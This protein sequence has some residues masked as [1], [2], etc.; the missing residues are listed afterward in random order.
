MFAEAMVRTGH[1]L[2]KPFPPE[3]REYWAGRFW[4]R[5]EVEAHSV[6]GDDFR[7]QKAQIAEMLQRYGGHAI[8]VIEIA[9][10]TGEFTAM[11][12]RL[13]EMK[14][15]VATDISQFALDKAAAR[16]RDPRATFVQAD[17]WAE[18]GLGAAD[19]VM[20]VDAIHH[21]GDVRAA[22]ERMKSHIAPGGV[23]VGNL[24]TLDNFHEYQR[25]RYGTIGHLGRS[26]RF[27]L[28]AIA[29]R[30]SGGRLRTSS[31][32]T[33]LL[34]RRDVGPLLSQ[35]FGEVIELHSTR[36]FTCFTCRP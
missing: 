32:R 33:Q 34:R 12:S 7:A 1:A 31:Y 3:G 26:A 11:A 22:L 21:L 16:V 10:G 36:H 8:R 25:E 27:L 24:W 19:L 29:M 30:V 28:T 13:P 4:D 18:G 17:F 15:M 14:E 23:F 9:C 2:V 20:C 35:V 5:E 6:L